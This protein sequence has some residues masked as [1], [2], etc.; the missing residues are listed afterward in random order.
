MAAQNSTATCATLKLLGPW[1]VSSYGYTYNSYSSNVVETPA[2][3][4]NPD[5]AG[6]GVS[7]VFRFLPF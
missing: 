2:I 1:L 4:S 3:T 6:T 7:S 5:I